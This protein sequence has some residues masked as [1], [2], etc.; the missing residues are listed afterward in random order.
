MPAKGSKRKI[1][2][3]SISVQQ[4]VS[5]P[6]KVKSTNNHHQQHNDS[7]TNGVADIDIDEENGGDDDEMHI[8]EEIWRKY[9]LD[10]PSPCRMHEQGSGAK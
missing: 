7:L 10:Q 4:H 1:K 8:D 3:P 9:R 6:K 2:V 5:P